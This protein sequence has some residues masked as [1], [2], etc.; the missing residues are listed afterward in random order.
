MLTSEIHQEMDKESF[1]RSQQTKCSGKGRGWM[2]STYKESS[3]QKY[4]ISRIV[5]HN[6]RE[7]GLVHNNNTVRG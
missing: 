4:M 5:S 7:I 1:T 3:T 2:F 6:G